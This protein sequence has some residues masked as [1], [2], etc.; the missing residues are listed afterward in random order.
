M[1]LPLRSEGISQTILGAPAMRKGEKGAEGS[2]F[3]GFLGPDHGGSGVYSHA[4]ATYSVQNPVVSP[5]RNRKLSQPYL[6]FKKMM[7]S[8]GMHADTSHKRYFEK[9]RSRVIGINWREKL[10]MIG[11]Q[12]KTSWMRWHLK[13]GWDLYPRNWEIF[14]AGI[15]AGS[16]KVWRVCEENCKQFGSA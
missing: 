4:A 8:W 1:D 15:K 5:V 10:L 11:L 6:L 16:W 7:V 2:K 9:V 13:N 14:Q 3:P 12:G